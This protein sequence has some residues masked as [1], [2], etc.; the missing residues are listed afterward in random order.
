MTG[1]CSGCRH[2]GGPSLAGDGPCGVLAGVLGLA[3]VRPPGTFGCRHYEPDDG[4]GCGVAMAAPMPPTLSAYGGR[5]EW[6]EPHLTLQEASDAFGV[7]RRTLWRW[8]ADGRLTAR[9][10]GRRVY[11]A[12]SE[13]RRLRDSPAPLPTPTGGGRAAA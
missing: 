11:I 5:G 3:V 7:S 6:A 13:V 1:T 10:V 9:R 2:W 12:R 4:S 8:I